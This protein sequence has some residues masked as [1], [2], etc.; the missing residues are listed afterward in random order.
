METFS[1]FDKG[2]EDTILDILNDFVS[3]VNEGGDNALEKR[4][5]TYI[6]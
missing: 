4:L 3:G 2:Q 6:I 1:V 5:C